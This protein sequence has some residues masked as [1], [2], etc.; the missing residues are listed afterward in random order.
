LK[1]NVILN[2]VHG[3]HLPLLLKN[4]DADPARPGFY[5]SD[6]T[7]STLVTTPVQVLAAPVNISTSCPD[8][9]IVE[10]YIDHNRIFSDPD[11]DLDIDLNKNHPK[12][13]QFDNF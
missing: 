3:V 6:I 12:Y 5:F 13:N 7:Y 2:T 1:H 9:D 8:K 11:P 4:W 10:S